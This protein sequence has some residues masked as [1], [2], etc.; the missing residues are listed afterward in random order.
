MQRTVI[1]AAAL[2]LG[3]WAADANAQGAPQSRGH[4][5]F[6][7]WC[8]PCHGP[9]LAKP[10]TAALQFKYKGDPPALL[11]Q[12]TD[13]TPE[14]V[15]TMVRTGVYTMPPFRKTEISD[16]DLDALTAYLSKTPPAGR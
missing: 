8:A 5:V 10:A 1:I 14:I 3:A 12:R 11:E 9:G 2:A 16:D 6:D 15:R 7:K 4:Q 13:L